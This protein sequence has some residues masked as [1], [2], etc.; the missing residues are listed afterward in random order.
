MKNIIKY[1]IAGL[2]CLCLVSPAFG[3]W[4]EKVT[5][6]QINVIEY[7]AKLKDGADPDKVERPRLRRDDN[8]KAKQSVNE[9]RDIMDDAEKLAR[10]GRHE[11]IKDPVFSFRGLSDE[12]AEEIFE[13]VPPIKE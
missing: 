1:V 11:E 10:E 4:K 12:R 9:L 6:N 3:F 5:R 13:V 7:V 2:L 8:Y